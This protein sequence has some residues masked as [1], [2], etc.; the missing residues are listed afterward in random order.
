MF[1]AD[2]C[3]EVNMKISLQEKLKVIDIQLSSIQFNLSL[4]SLILQGIPRLISI[5]VKLRFFTATLKILNINMSCQK[6]ITR[7]LALKNLSFF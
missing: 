6:A 2:R 7:H 3:F 1:N 5:T 4:R